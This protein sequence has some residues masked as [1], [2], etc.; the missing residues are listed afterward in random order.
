LTKPSPDP[1]HR[2]VATAIA[3]VVWLGF[4]AVPVAVFLGVIR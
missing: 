4:T 2:S 1:L 3:L